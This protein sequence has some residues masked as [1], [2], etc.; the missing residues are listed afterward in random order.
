MGIRF[1]NSYLK[2]NCPTSIRHINMTELK[3]KKIA[4]DISIYLYKYQADNILMENIFSMLAIF[5]EYDIIPIFI[6]DGNAPPEK[7]ELLKK[8]KED[9]IEAQKEFKLLKEELKNKELNFEDKQDI[10]TAMDQLK[11]QI[12]YITKERIEKV[13]ELI[14]A[15]GS[16]YYDAHGE[17]DELCAMLVKNKKVW[18]CMSEDMDMF[19]YGCTRVLRYFS[20]VHHTAVLYHIPGIL[21][22]LKMKMQDFRQICV[23]SGTDYNMMNENVNYLRET[24]ELFQD[25][26][27]KLTSK[28]N[29]DNFYDWIL[30]NTNYIKDINILNKIY[31]MFDLNAN[32]N[33]CLFDKICI[34]DGPTNRENVIKILEDE[35]FFFI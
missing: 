23:L 29:Y 34:M 3:G 17:A 2:K 11:R 27:N 16:T 25:Y 5:K 35:G 6:F 19:V 30:K 15:Y 13:K 31:K 7:K 10:I 22:E 1:L 32:E 8:R 9:K 21:K 4:I 28:E 24:I 26:Q 18:A 20:L 12:V 14:R 33:L